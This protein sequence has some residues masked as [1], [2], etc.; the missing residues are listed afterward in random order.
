MPL[1]YHPAVFYSWRWGLTRELGEAMFRFTIALMIGYLAFSA[2]ADATVKKSHA[3]VGCTNPENLPYLSCDPR[4]TGLCSTPN[5][6][7]DAPPY[8]NNVTSQAYAAPVFFVLD[9]TSVKGVITGGENTFSVTGGPLGP[10]TVNCRWYT[11]G[12]TQIFG[13]GGHVNGYCTARI[14]KRYFPPHH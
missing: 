13:S 12:S 1:V 9:P 11:A 8:Q 14:A 3:S 2:D 10:C 6:E 4:N 7:L 5:R